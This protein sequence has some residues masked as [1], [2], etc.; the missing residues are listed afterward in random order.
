M[1][2]GSSIKPWKFLL[3]LKPL[4]GLYV[5]R[6]LKS[7]MWR[8]IKY[9]EIY[10]KE[11]ASPREDRMELTAYLQWYNQRRLHQSLNYQTP[12]RVYFSLNKDGGCLLN[13]SGS[14]S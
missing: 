3:F 12:A 13:S 4:I 8:T 6:N 9:E 10:L 1:S 7:G 14:L 5:R 11:Y 2:V